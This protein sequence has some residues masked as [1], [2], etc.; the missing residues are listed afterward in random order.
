M[1]ITKRQLRRIIKE[2]MQAVVNEKYEGSPQHELDIW[3]SR[4]SIGTDAKESLFKRLEDA[5]WS[6]PGTGK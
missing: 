4:R 5:G 6:P 3:F 2:E 1:R